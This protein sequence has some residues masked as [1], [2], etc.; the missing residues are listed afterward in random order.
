MLY[1]IKVNNNKSFKVELDEVNPR[2]GTINETPFELN[3]LQLEKGMFH[4]IR[5]NK[6]YNAQLVSFDKEAKSMELSINGNIYTL[7]LSDKYDELLKS[8]G[9]DTAML[10]KVN[11]LKAPMPGLVLDIM[12]EPGSTVSKGDS[13]LVLEA[14]KMENIL[15]APA[16]GIVKS[17]NVNKK[18]AVEKNQVLISF[19]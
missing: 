1:H 14:M 18:N 5:N 8:L 15:K 3:L 17:I 19:E 10:S 16:D 2:K 7:Q 9:M 12:V 11:E 13:L 6:S 4:V